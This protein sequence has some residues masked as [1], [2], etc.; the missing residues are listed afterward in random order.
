MLNFRREVRAKCYLL[1]RKLMLKIEYKYSDTN[2]NRNQHQPITVS[3]LVLLLLL[4]I[5]S[6]R[7]YK[8]VIDLFDF[9][10]IAFNPESNR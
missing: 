5:K 4:R 10:S 3:V 6:Y 7:D 2:R 1:L 8:T 9:T